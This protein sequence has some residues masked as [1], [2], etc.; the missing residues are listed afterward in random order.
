M[1]TLRTATCIF[2]CLTFF[3]LP[4]MKYILLLIFFFHY[5]ILFA[6]SKENT[7][8][9]RWIKTKVTYKDGEPLSD[10]KELK[11]SYLRYSFE[12]SDKAFVALAYEDKGIEMN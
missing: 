2:T 12:S 1:S 11:Y 6:Q 4:R 3:V 5:S 8:L 7:L 10:A 9:G